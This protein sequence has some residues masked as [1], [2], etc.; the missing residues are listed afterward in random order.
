M[1]ILI[2]VM[3]YVSILSNSGVNS[4][5]NK[6][7]AIELTNKG[8]ARPIPSSFADP[9]MT[10][11]ISGPEGYSLFTFTWDG[12]Y[13]VTS[14]TLDNEQLF[15]GENAMDFSHIQSVDAYW[16]DDK[17]VLLS[18]YQPGIIFGSFTYLKQVEGSRWEKVDI[19]DYSDNN[20][21]FLDNN[22]V[23]ELLDD[24]LAEK[25]GEPPKHSRFSLP[26]YLAILLL[27]LV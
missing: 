13:H 5:N 6:N 2:L 21:Y 25:N 23:K 11:Q 14:V 10:K 18:F 1:T 16:K 17:P 9:Y 4:R 8:P 19:R 24:I 20:S 15:K 22:E 7:V 3:A 26:S 12:T 27:F